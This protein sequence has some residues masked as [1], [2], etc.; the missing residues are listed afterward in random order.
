MD[1]GKKYIWL[2]VVLAVTVAAMMAFTPPDQWA[3]MGGIIGLVV[4]FIAAPQVPV[5]RRFVLRHTRGTIAVGIGAVVAGFL[6]L[7]GTI[8]LA[9]SIHTNLSAGAFVLLITVGALV[10]SMP[11]MARRFEADKAIWKAMETVPRTPGSFHP[12]AE[13]KEILAE[14]IDQ[15]GALARVA[16]PWFLLF[17]LLPLAFVDLDYWKSLADRDRGLAEMILLGLVV[18]ILLEIAFLLVATIQWTRFAATKQEPRLTAFPGKALWGW[19]WRWMIYGGLFRSIDRV[20][21]W[22]KAH[23]PAAA[24][25][26]LDGLQGLIGLAALILFSPFALVLPAVALNAAD[27]GIA[28]SMRGF[29]LVGRKYYLGAALI[30]APYA[31]TSWV[32]GIL[33][34]AYKGPVAVVANVG[35]SALLLFVTMIVGMTYLTR[36]YLRGAAA[37]GGTA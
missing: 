26:Q 22:I 33:Y 6:V 29:R 37:A 21:P 27:R 25:W 30:L 31:V 5:V 23:L 17:C 14:L 7:F 15:R 36:I 11:F 2:A 12:E 19:S 1:L 32:L 10:I 3:E 4:L 8:S 18:V 9:P 20:Q 16:G 28:A 24:P 34:A 13:V 35:A